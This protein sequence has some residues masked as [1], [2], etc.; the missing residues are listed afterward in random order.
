M[1]V[2]LCLRWVISVGVAY[3]VLCDMAESSH[4]FYTV[5]VSSGVRPSFYFLAF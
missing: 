3:L 5:T 1:F 4:Q 2:Y